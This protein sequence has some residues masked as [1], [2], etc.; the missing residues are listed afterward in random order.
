MTKLACGIIS[1][2]GPCAIGGRHARAADKR[3]SRVPGLRPI[4]RPTHG[5]GWRWANKITGICRKS[6]I[7]RDSWKNRDNP[8]ISYPVVNGGSCEGS[9]GYLY[10]QW[11]LPPDR[12]AKG[13]GAK[14][15]HRF[16]DTNEMLFSSW[17]WPRKVFAQIGQLCFYLS[18][19]YPLAG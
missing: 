6:I 17:N 19:H 2:L 8:W 3:C 18:F 16:R 7:N 11:S 1:H 10:S 4:Q 14:P 15:A 5:P 13:N 12:W 9:L